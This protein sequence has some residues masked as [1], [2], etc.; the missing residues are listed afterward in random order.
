MYL[1]YQFFPIWDIKY[2]TWYT[3]YIISDVTFFFWKT[4][5]NDYKCT[6]LVILHEK[7]GL[8]EKILQSAPRFHA[9]HRNSSV[10]ESYIHAV[11]S[12][13]VLELSQWF[14]RFAMEIA[15]RLTKG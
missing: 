11:W 4:W 7:L 6:M 15:N 9:Y 13:S 2:I 14:S 5:H 8:T 12:S 3:R 1:V 10:P